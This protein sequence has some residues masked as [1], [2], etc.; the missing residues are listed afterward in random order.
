M[1]NQVVFIFILIVFLSCSNKV[2]KPDNLIS[3]EKMVDI[4]YEAS[5]LTAAKGVNKKALEDKGIEP[6]NFVYS[7][8]NIDSL[9]FVNSLDYYA[10]S[11]ETYDN[12][13]TKVEER[14][15]ADKEL[16]EDDIKGN[17]KE[18]NKKVPKVNKLIKNSNIDVLN[19]IN[20]DVTFDEVGLKIEETDIAF[21]DESVFKVSR[22]SN[23]TPAYL[24]IKNQKITSGET[25]LVTIY[26]QK[27]NDKSALGLRISGIYPNRVDAIFD[28]ENSKLIGVKSKGYFEN[29]DASIELID[30]EWYKCTIS[31]KANIDEIQIIYG[32]TDA[33]K[34]IGSWEGKS[35]ILSQVNVTV[36]TISRN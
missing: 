21:I 25:V 22:I 27:T 29:E 28:L 33:D 8:F 10:N 30:E 13:Y 6:E 2:K 4:I 36:P 3:E 9:Q 7:K 23:N 1:K 17:K 18:T 19:T 12:I 16:Y 26:V 35:A 5:I 24:I 11:I 20:R 15:N 32:P 14:L 34:P 31:A